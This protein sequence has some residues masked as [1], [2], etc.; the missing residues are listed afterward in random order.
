M[1]ALKDPRPSRPC[2]R[3]SMDSFA[4][5]LIL[6]VAVIASQPIGRFLRVAPLPIVQ[7]AIG[8]ALAWPV[9]GGVHV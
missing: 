5:V 3:K 1:D 8:A 2:E 6:V 7:I 9:T 4:F